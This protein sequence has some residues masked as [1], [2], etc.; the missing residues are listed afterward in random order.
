MVEAESEYDPG[1]SHEPVRLSRCKCGCA[2]AGDEC[3]DQVRTREGPIHKGARS[4]WVRKCE[5]E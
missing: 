3:A 4:E 2:D 5:D 1:G